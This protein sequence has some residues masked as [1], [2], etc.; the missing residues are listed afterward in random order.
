[1]VTYVIGSTY[2]GRKTVACK[3]PN[4]AI[5]WSGSLTAAPDHNIPVELQSM[6]S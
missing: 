1:M 2:V 3:N 4:F 5:I 6:G